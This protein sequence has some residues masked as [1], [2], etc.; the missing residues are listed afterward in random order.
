MSSRLERAR[1]AMAIGI[2]SGGVLNTV[3]YSCDP[4]TVF[5]LKAQKGAKDLPPGQ[6]KKLKRNRVVRCPKSVCAKIMVITGNE[7]W[8]RDCRVCTACSAHFWMY[9]DSMTLKELEAKYK[10][11]EAK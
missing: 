10:R 7:E 1:E 5:Y 6:W 3:L 11:E 4:T 8:T 9:F 2:A